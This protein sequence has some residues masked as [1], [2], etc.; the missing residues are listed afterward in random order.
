MTKQQVRESLSMIFD[1]DLGDYWY[2]EETGYFKNYT[3][4]D[5]EEEITMFYKVNIIVHTICGKF[6]WNISNYYK[7]YNECYKKISD[8]KR[9]MHDNDILI[10]DL[11]TEECYTNSYFID[12]DSIKG[13]EI[14][15]IKIDN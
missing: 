15:Y 10:I 14:E 7:Y 3:Y 6:I 11:Q 4:N 1:L 2:D 5:N 8:D 13:F 12:Y 9:L